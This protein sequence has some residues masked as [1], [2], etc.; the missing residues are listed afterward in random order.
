MAAPPTHPESRPPA[1]LR[2]LDEVVSLGNVSRACHTLGHSRDSFHRFNELYEKGGELALAEMSR[3]RLVLK[4]RSPPEVEQAAC[5]ITRRYVYSSR[6]ARRMLSR[7][8]LRR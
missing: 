7:M 3:R 8:G 2:A 4:N 6:M 1:S 5:A